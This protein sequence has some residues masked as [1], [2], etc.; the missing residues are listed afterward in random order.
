M[1]GP[2][3][4]V[5]LM[6]KVLIQLENKLQPLVVGTKN[7]GQNGATYANINDLL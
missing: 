3:G 7:I 4:N 2:Q 6:N 5:G 1:K